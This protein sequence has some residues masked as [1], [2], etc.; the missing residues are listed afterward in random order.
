MVT[1]APC[2]N[3]A[4]IRAA[5]G[6]KG[7]ASSGFSILMMAAA[8]T[9]GS[10]A[11]KTCSRANPAR[12]PSAQINHLRPLDQAARLQVDPLLAVLSGQFDPVAD[13]GSPG[14]SSKSGAPC[15]VRNAVI[16]RMRVALR[17]TRTGLRAIR[18]LST[19]SPSPRGHRRARRFRPCAR[20]GRS[21]RRD[22]PAHG[23]GQESGCPSA[24]RWI[25]LSMHPAVVTQ[26][27]KDHF[28]R[29]AH[30]GQLRRIAEQHQ[31]GKNLAQILE[32]ALIQHGAFIDKTRCPAVLRAASSP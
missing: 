5:E 19:R 16:S 3:A 6:I 22:P 20:T 4:P 24:W 8:E 2:R 28:P 30:R 1:A 21:Q 14:R 31:R 18:S 25:R 9:C 26:P 29:Q 27:V 32:L 11:P 15:A 17:Q 10:S 23:P 13:Q 12:L 7:S